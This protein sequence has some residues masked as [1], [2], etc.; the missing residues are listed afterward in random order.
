MADGGFW[1]QAVLLVAVA[2]SGGCCGEVAPS[3]PW[4]AG[5]PHSIKPPYPRHAE[6]QPSDRRWWETETD[7]AHWFS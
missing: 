7:I 6:W 5:Q 1:W 3:V 2:A 4:A